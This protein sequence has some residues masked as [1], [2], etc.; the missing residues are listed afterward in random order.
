MNGHPKRGFPVLLAALLLVGGV[1]ISSLAPDSQAARSATVRTVAGSVGDLCPNFTAPGATNVSVLTFTISDTVNN[2][3]LTGVAVNY[4]GT[5]IADLKAAH[6]YRESGNVPGTFDNSTDT[7]LASNSS[8]TGSPIVISPSFNLRRNND[9]QFYI[10]FDIADNATDGDKVDACI[11]ADGLTVA[12]NTWP[13]AAYDPAGFATIDASAPAGWAAFAPAGWSRSQTV[14]CTVSVGDLRSGLAVSTAEYQWSNDS[15]AGWSAWKRANCTGTNGTAADQTISAT[16]VAFGNDSAGA[17]LVRFRV[18]DTVGN[19][20][21]SPDYTVRLDTAAPGGWLLGSPLGWYT[22]DMRPTVQI[23]VGDISSGLD[24]GTV[25]ARYSVDGGQNWTAAPSVNCSG[26]S[27]SLAPENVTAWSVPFD[28]D[29]SSMDLIRFNVSDVAGN[30]NVSPAYTIKIDATPPDAPALA[31]LPRYANGS[32]VA[33]SW[34]APPD[35]VSGLDRFLA[36]CDDA[37][38]LSSPVQTVET[39]NTTCAFAG[40]SDGA[41]YYYGVRSVNNA[42]VAGNFSVPLNCTQ[43]ASAP[44]TV[45]TTSP[46]G[47]DGQNGWFLTAVN[48]SFAA[49]DNTSGVAGTFFAVN[50][51]AP[52]EGNGTLLGQGG[53]YNVSF[54]SEDNV[55]NVEPA[56]NVTIKI[57]LSTPVAAMHAPEKVFT[58]ETAFFDAN[59]SR[60]VGQCIWDFGDGSPNATGISVQHSFIA[61][62]VYHVTLTV[63]DPAG[64]TCATA[65]DVRVLDRNVNYPPKAVIGSLGTIYVGEPVTFDGRGSRDEEP[66]LLKF[67]WDFGDG[68]TGTGPSATHT[69]PREGDFKVSLLVT[70]PLDLFDIAS[71]AVR[72]YIKGQ[73]RPPLAQMTQLNIAYVNEQVFFDGSNSTDEDLP[74]CVFSWD[75]GDGAGGTGLLVSHAYASDGTFLVRLNI[76][77][78]PGLTGSTQLSVR[79]FQRGVNL[80]PIAQFTFHPF[81]S[82]VGEKVDFDASLTMDEDTFSLNYTWDFGDGSGGQGKLATHAYKDGGEYE[83]ILRVRDQGGLGDVYS[84]KVTVVKPSSPPPAAGGIVPWAV[85]A[86]VIILVALAAVVFLARRRRPAPPP[87]PQ[88]IPHAPEGPQSLIAPTPVTHTPSEVVIEE[89]LNYLIDRETPDVAYET[90]ARLASE[91]ASALLI[92][93]VHPNKVNKGYNMENVQIFWLSEITGEIPSIDPAKMEYELAE[94][95]ITFI[96]E[97]EANAVVALDGLELLVQRHGFDK[98][99]EFI[100]TINEVGSVSGATVLVNVNGKAMKEVE[101]NQ[102]RRKFDRW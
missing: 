73:N 81:K 74:D 25:S 22:A 14:D 34:L 57:D 46:A 93:P 96:K 87:P 23:S 101:L 7:L 48:L 5:S 84:G 77:D 62:G 18:N 68:T 37:G 39:N 42:G 26:P 20:G 86:V 41:T 92:T 16:A 33:I 63:V 52:S 4:T 97:K 70:D 40:L 31:P 6:L 3:L 71:R 32:S 30:W 28:R 95:M 66:E 15:G 78:P 59:G 79:V 27:G 29:S 11:D 54:W 10:V 88:E 1:F 60:D 2:Q 82:K 44:F 76:T 49:V 91:G 24:N 8:I 67:A 36:V 83:V 17:N 102:L 51:G 12:G 9:R 100:H 94:K 56:G 35:A 19:H 64:R 13:D 85:A 47:P 90:V 99:M 75:F 80:P 98:V 69:Y 21:A 72:V 55:G 65:A 45:L 89:G 61:A 43:D 38:D 58:N 50:G 53:E